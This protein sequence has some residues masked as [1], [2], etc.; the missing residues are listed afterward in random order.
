MYKWQQGRETCDS[1]EQL[2]VGSSH[3]LTIC[4]PLRLFWRTAWTPAV[5][6]QPAG[7]RWWEASE[8]WGGWGRGGRGWRRRWSKWS[9]SPSPECRLIFDIFATVCNYCARSQRFSAAG[10]ENKPAEL[11]QAVSTVQ[12]IKSV[13]TYWKNQTR[14]LLKWTRKWTKR[15]TCFLFLLRSHCQFI[16]TEFS[17]R[18]LSGHCCYGSWVIVTLW[19]RIQA[20][21]ERFVFTRH[22]SS[23]PQHRLLAN[24]RGLSPAGVFTYVHM[25][26]GSS[27]KIS[28]VTYFFIFSLQ[29]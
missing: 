22:N 7:C 5:R 26:K 2:V 29:F 24:Q 25:Y 17:L 1:C 6:P 18:S 11:Q 21:L 28:R 8:E 19:H 3:S 13:F 10:P 4:L 9:W 20:N 14:S 23:E 27:V 12:A 16:W 15:K